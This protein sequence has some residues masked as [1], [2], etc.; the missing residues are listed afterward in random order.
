MIKIKEFEVRGFK[1]YENAQI[2]FQD[3]YGIANLIG[4][5]DDI[6]NF[7]SNS[8]GK[9]SFANIFLQ[10]IYGKNLENQAQENILHKYSNTPF[11]GKITL[12]IEGKEIIIIRDNSKSGKDSLQYYVDGVY[13][14]KTDEKEYKTRKAEIQDEIDTLL[15]MGVTTFKKLLYLSPNEKT[16]FSISSD[17]SQ[18]KFI[19]ELLNLDLITQINTRA[20]KEVTAYKNEIVLKSREMKLL[21]THL[22]SIAEQLKSIPKEMDEKVLINDFNDISTKLSDNDKFIQSYKKQLTELKDSADIK[23]KNV[24]NIQGQVSALRKSLVEKQ[25]L[26]KDKK[27]PTCGNDIKSELL[28]ITDL[29]QEISDKEIEISNLETEIN[30]SKATF[31][32]LKKEYD[33]CIEKDTEYKGIIK[34]IE[35]QKEIL[36]SNGLKEMKQKLQ[37]DMVDKSNELIQLQ[38]DLNEAEDMK[39][40]LDLI[41]QCSSDKG[42]IKSRIDLFLRLFNKRLF[43]LASKLSKGDLILRVKKDTK[44]NYS[45]YIKDSRIELSYEELSSGL[46][47]RVDLLLNLT[48]RKSLEDLTG[49]KVN[50]LIIDE[51]I[52]S[53]DTTG[54]ESIVELLKE[55][56]KEFSD[57]LIFIVSHGVAM[58][59][60]DY[61]LL[62]HRK[63]NSSTLKWL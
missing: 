45:L 33:K 26:I 22:E 6:I 28:H 48:L 51:L 7:D 10:I 55:I 35:S 53:V 62:V 47:A 43:E 50:I 42:F 46:K 57:T 2:S 52:G 56:K 18:S 38:S 31:D 5:N 15:G 29:E 41:T 40:C 19:Q 44:N 49:I 23:K 25:R 4:R 54:R 32:S 17:T 36:E 61:D 30:S 21:Q 1:L 59:T 13:Q 58:P 11:S 24:S 14:G 12:E 9:S 37:K 8:S 39:Y 27:C 3:K 63:G 16:L 34:R 20:K 60:T